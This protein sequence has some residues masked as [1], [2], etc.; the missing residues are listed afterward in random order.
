MSEAGERLNL[1]GADLL[2]TIIALIVSVGVPQLVGVIGAWVTLPAVQSWYPTL[3]KPWFTPP[4]W[5]FGPAWVTLYAAMGVASFLVWRVGWSNPAVKVALGW[6]VGQLVL[7][8]LWSPAFFGLESPTLGLVVIIP[9]WI[10]VVVTIGYFWQ[11][12]RWA[13]ILLIPYLAWLTYA[14]ALNASIWWLN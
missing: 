14:T 9:L 10:A 13:G 4:N 7:N 11:V 6:Y 8:A 2:R 5:L 1:S 3:T 12:S